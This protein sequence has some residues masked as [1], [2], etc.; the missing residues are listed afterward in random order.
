MRRFSSLEFRLAVLV[1]LGLIGFSLA[2]GIFTYNYSYRNRLQQAQSLQ[3]QLVRT[4]Q[5]QAEVAAFAYNEKIARGVIDGLL[6]NPS[7]L[8][9][10][11][12]ATEHSHLALSS[13]GSL[14]YGGSTVY[15]LLSPVD[16]TERIGRLS[17]VQ[18]EN[19][20]NREAAQYALFQTLLMLAQVALATILMIV[21][22]R[23]VVTRPVADL[24]QSMRA[25]KPGS[26]ERLD[27][28]D[29]H[30]NDEIGLLSHSANIL[31]EATETAIDDERKLRNLLDTTNQIAR[32]GGWT[33]DL[34]TKSMMLSEEIFRINEVDPSKL[35]ATL[36]V[37]VEQAINH[38]APTSRPAIAAA[39]QAGIDRG[40]EFDLELQWITY[41][42]KTIWVRTQ[43][44]AERENGQVVCL[45]GAMQDISDRK[46]TEQDLRIAATAFESQEGMLIT[47]A[48]EVILRVNRA[49]CE[50]TGYS[51]AEA[52]GKT[53]R[54]LSS[55][56][57]DAAF[58]ASIWS[59]IRN[60]G[61]WQGEIWNRRKN[62][63]VYPQWLTIT[64]VKDDDGEITHY[65]GT[66]T[67][68]T[69]RKAA[70]D[71]IKHLA[72]Y[73]PLTHLPNRRLLIDRLHQ[74]LSTSRRNQ[75][76]G[77]L[78]FIDLDKF[79]QINDTLGHDIG[80]LLLQNVGQR[81]LSCLRENDTA[82][83]IGGDEFIVMLEY[84][85][86]HPEAAVQQVKAVAEKILDTLNVPYTLATHECRSSPS[87]GIALFL[88]HTHTVSELLKQ[89]DS[90][91]YQ[92]KA[93]GR[94]V[95]RFF[96]TTT[97]H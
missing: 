8:A 60:I 92:A 42:G 9:A 36:P 48:N 88:G 83:R 22:L 14:D 52:I 30:A 31:L 82:A 39:L 3:R 25:I 74:A 12:E 29:K 46:Q 2:A 49:Y 96:D 87:I 51:A 15:P 69:V 4:V 62:G 13:N 97:G 40:A 95:Y 47:D 50:I 11:L 93:A 44:K 89:A 94:N 91:M 33:Y 72:F 81:L 59:N 32:V 78:L 70:E 58:Y 84:L 20:V 77:A 73:D 85:D 16:Q 61:T 27:I 21:V 35:D 17:V 54:M 28:E 10:R 79:K 80:D 63:E 90:A 24:A 34:A 66:L 65:V 56:R 67:D 86:E 7:I 5:A 64:A 26:P 41:T 76:S 75:R 1:G 68:I 19:H 38:F 18:N 57:H 23:F 37:S 6:A 55:N 53:P 43:G 71:E 45:Y